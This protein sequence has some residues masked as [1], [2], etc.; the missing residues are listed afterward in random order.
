VR[1]ETINPIHRIFVLSYEILVY[2]FRYRYSKVVDDC[3]S[4]ISN[5]ASYVKAYFRRAKARLELGKLNDAKEDVKTTLKLE[6]S[7]VEAKQLLAQISK[8][9]MSTL[10]GPTSK[11]ASSIQTTPNTPTPSTPTVRN[12]I[13][14]GVRTVL[15]SGGNLNF[16]NS[17]MM[18]DDEEDLNAK[19]DC[20]VDKKQYPKKI[21]PVRKVAERRSKVRRI[22]LSYK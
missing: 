15:G 1:K 14:P 13:F 3:T 4:S 10:F 2:Y 16:L 5:D 18:D 20:V 11:S 12:S 6:P 19:G 17:R 7:N 9:T 21:L 8:K 22:L